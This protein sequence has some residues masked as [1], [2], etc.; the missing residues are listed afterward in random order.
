VVFVVVKNQICAPIPLSA[1]L[2]A[3][4]TV[5]GSCP[6][7]TAVQNQSIAEV[8]SSAT[9]IKPPDQP[10]NQPAE[11][12]QAEAA[13]TIASTTLPIAPVTPTAPAPPTT[14]GTSLVAESQPIAQ[15]TPDAAL[16]APP[17]EAT[18]S[19]TSPTAE[20]APTAQSTPDAAPPAPPTE[21]PG[22]APPAGVPG[23]TPPAEAPLS[24]PAPPTD[25][26][27]EPK[28]LVGEVLVQGVTGELQNLIYQVIST[29]PGQTATRSQLQQDINAI[30]STGYFSD[31]RAEPSDTPL[32]VRVT[33]LVQP[34]PAL[35]AVQG[36][37]NQILTQSKIDEIFA[38][39][40]GQNINLRQIKQ[41]IDQIN[42][43]YQDNGYILGQVVGSP[44][45]S[46]DGVVTLQ[47]AE[48][49]VEK[50]TPKFLSKENQPVKGRTRDYVIT[51]ELKTKPGVVL[52]RN[53]VQT[54]L[55][56]LFG[57]GLFEDVQVAL[58]PGEDPR[59][60]NLVLNIKERK[61]GN[62]SA[63]AGFSSV[64]GLFG[65][66]S[67]QQNNLFGRNQRVSA[68]VQAGTRGE[69]LFDVGFT[70]PWIK[71]DPYRTSYTVNVFNRLTTPFVFTGG[72]NEVNVCNVDEL[73]GDPADTDNCDEDRIRVNRLGGGIN[74][75][76]P[77]TKDLD[78]VR[79]AW[80]ASVGLQYQ[81]VS[82]RDA[83]FAIVK[84]DQEGNPLSFSGTGQDDLLLLQAAIARDL[85]NDPT[86]PTKGSFLRVGVEQSVP[87][88]LGSILLNRIRANYSYYI[89]IKFLK[90]KKPGQTLAFNVQGGTVLGD[91]PPYE[92]FSLGGG[93]SVRGYREGELGS[94][95][96]FL[97]GT[98]E[99]RF[100][101][102][103]IVGG[104]LFIDA[105]TTFGTQG[106]VL[107]KPGL[108]RDK[109]GQGIGFGGGVRVN[110]P[111]GNIRID[112]G[113]NDRGDSELSFGI[114]ERF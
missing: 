7:A 113:F 91:L 34:Y 35:R 78:K 88:G 83:D 18:P 82:L 55:Q 74:F 23:A 49:V 63:G 27:P 110:T 11:L 106:D 97:Q 28:V 46:P 39:Q 41:G 67:Y 62:I 87:V 8:E 69:I 51:R 15:A 16:P 114:G 29:R 103:S 52:N 105:A 81:R 95:R 93:N 6:I 12:V 66:A 94:G 30:F 80:T 22:A 19:L 1:G 109:P 68:E 42:K 64:S 99:Y 44:Q 10:P 71:G 85:R 26:T 33:F 4:L 50:I 75:T 3:I 45:V 76:R 25:G 24:V 36:S 53:T 89:P 37:G 14:A 9:A 65:T 108:V 61:T 101:L 111:L 54:D 79:N 2:I 72:D 77:F 90:T 5:L 112:Y 96:S 98:V 73:N 57:L 17:T 58:E 48:G 47:I 31:V 40:I 21:T 13:V 32:G 38:P 59:K 60:V 102:F 86:K 84:R 92:A 104:A 20:G 107:G 100:P 56:R 43:Y 70:N